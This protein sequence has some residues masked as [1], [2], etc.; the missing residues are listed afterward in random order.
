MWA[1]AALHTR[2][3]TNSAHPLVAANRRVAGLPGVRVLPATRE[4]VLATA[5]QRSEELDLGG[6]VR[7]CAYRIGGGGRRPGFGNGILVPLQ[8]RELREKLASLG[9]ER[10]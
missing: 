2:F 1:L 5:K 7:R 10:L 8:P 4:H 6:G 3:F 9:L